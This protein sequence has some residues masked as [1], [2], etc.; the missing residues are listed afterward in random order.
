MG[1]IA[2]CFLE[3]LPFVSEKL[4][5]FFWMVSGLLKSINFDHNFMKLV[6]NVLY[7]YVFLKSDNGLYDL[8]PSS[9]IV[10]L[11]FQNDP[12]HLVFSRVMALCS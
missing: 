5:F 2:L 11:K 9:V 7:H 8:M 3:L 10:L 1:D 12:Y 6:L 4:P